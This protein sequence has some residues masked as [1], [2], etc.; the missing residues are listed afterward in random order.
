MAEMYVDHVEDGEDSDEENNDD[1]DNDNGY[2]NDMGAMGAMGRYGRGALGKNLTVEE[3]SKRLWGNTYLDPS[4][5]RFKK[6][7]SDCNPGNTPRTFCQ[8][9]LE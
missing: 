9:V 1:Y 7:S 6:R 2:D 8:F 5:R 3:F 4:S